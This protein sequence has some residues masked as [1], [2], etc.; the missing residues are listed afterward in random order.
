MA[1]NRNRRKAER[2]RTVEA[3]LLDVVVP[4]PNYEGMQIFTGASLKGMLS[5]ARKLLNRCLKPPQESDRTD[6][7][8]QQYISDR[9]KTEAS[10][11]DFLTLPE[12]AELI[13]YWLVINPKILSISEFFNYP[14]DFAPYLYDLRSIAEYGS[15]DIYY[16]LE[17][18]I[19]TAALHKK[20]DR[21][22]A[23]ALL[24]EKFSWEKNNT[25]NVNLS[26][27]GVIDFQFG[28]ANL[29]APKDERK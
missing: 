7:P 29:N 18:R 12:Y 2:T 17:D 19:Q 3:S 26:T 25:Q 6:T 22:V 11:A 15:E 20:V 5:N 10:Y 21:E 9:Y 27:G 23:M 1:D 13:Y 8:A 4:S 24:R 16:L 28:D 14:L